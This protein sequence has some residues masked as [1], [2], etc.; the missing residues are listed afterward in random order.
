MLVVI[1]FRIL[2]IGSILCVIINSIVNEKIYKN[3]LV[4]L[5]KIDRHVN[6]PG[7]I[8]LATLKL[9]FTNK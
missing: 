3:N 6:I 2:P 1:T 8:L 9:D 4:E 5:K 7:S